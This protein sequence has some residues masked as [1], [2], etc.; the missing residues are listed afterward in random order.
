MLSKYLMVCLVLG[1]W[2][3]R[4]NFLKIVILVLAFITVLTLKNSNQMGQFLKIHHTI[5]YAG[6]FFCWYS[7]IRDKER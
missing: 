6:V 2:Y 4:F 5:W 1:I 7:D 3:D